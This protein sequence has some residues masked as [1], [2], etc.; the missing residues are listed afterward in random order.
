[1]LISY[2]L[3]SHIRER[4]FCEKQGFVEVT[5]QSAWPTGRWTAQVVKIVLGSYL[6]HSEDVRVLG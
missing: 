1:M 6:Q 4:V 2:V 3:T 5:V